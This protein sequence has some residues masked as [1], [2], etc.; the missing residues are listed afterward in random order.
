M[1]KFCSKEF[2]S[3]S[4]NLEKDKL[5]NMYKELSYKQQK[6]KR[7]ISNLFYRINKEELLAK[8]SSSQENIIDCRQQLTSAIQEKEILNK[9]IAILQKR[10][11]FLEN[12]IRKTKPW[13]Q[14]IFSPM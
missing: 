12:E 1:Q 14:Q 8:E 3:N 9:D 4:V 2:K 11:K 13:W 7:V 10:L 6:V 5:Q